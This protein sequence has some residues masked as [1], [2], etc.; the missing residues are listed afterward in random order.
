MELNK[1]CE[2]KREALNLVVSPVKREKRAGQ[3]RCEGR[4]QKRPGRKRRVL[5]YRS[6]VADSIEQ[7][8]MNRDKPGG[9]TLSWRGTEARRVCR[10]NCKKE[11]GKRRLARDD[12]RHSEEAG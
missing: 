6:G 3:S 4:R 5:A 10:Y 1:G 9:Q 7:H 2:V 11:S 12:G 8:I